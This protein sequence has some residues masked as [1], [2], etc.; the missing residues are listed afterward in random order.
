MVIREVTATGTGEQ[1]FILE[2]ESVAD[3]NRAVVG[4]EIA[5]ALLGRGILTGT[6]GPLTDLVN[7]GICEAYDGLAGVIRVD[8]QGIHRWTGEARVSF[9]AVTTGYSH[10]ISLTKA[11]LI[12]LDS[13]DALHILPEGGTHTISAV[14]LNP[15]NMAREA[16]VAERRRMILSHE[17]KVRGLV[18]LIGLSRQNRGNER[19]SLSAAKLIGSGTGPNI[20]LSAEYAAIL[21]G[22]VERAPWNFTERATQEIVD[23]AWK[24]L[25]GARDLIQYEAEAHQNVTDAIRTTV[26]PAA[27]TEIEARVEAAGLHL[28]SYIG[29]HRRIREWRRDAIQAVVGT[30][31]GGTHCQYC[32]PHEVVQQL[33]SKYF[34]WLGE[35]LE[36]EIQLTAHQVVVTL[37]VRCRED[38]ASSPYLYILES[39]AA[40]L[41][42]QILT[43][44]QKVAIAY[45]PVSGY[46]TKEAMD[47]FKSLC[48]GAV[49]SLAGLTTVGTRKHVEGAILDSQALEKH[50]VAVH[51]ASLLLPPEI[52]TLAELLSDV[53]VNEAR[54]VMGI[55]AKA[56]RHDMPI[57]RST[58][59]IPITWQTPAPPQIYVEYLVRRSY[60]ASLEMSEARIVNALDIFCHKTGHDGMAVFARNTSILS[61]NKAFD[62]VSPVRPVR[63]HQFQ[64]DYLNRL[65]TKIVS[66]V[67]TTRPEE[68]EQDVGFEPFSGVEDP[69]L[70]IDLGRLAEELGIPMS[71][72]LETDQM[73]NYVDTL[74]AVMMQQTGVS[75][76]LRMFEY[77]RA[78]S[79]TYR[80]A[81]MANPRNSQNRIRIACMVLR[82][83]RRMRV[84]A[85][86]REDLLVEDRATYETFVNTRHALIRDAHEAVHPPTQDESGASVT[87]SPM[88]VG[89]LSPSVSGMTWDGAADFEETCPELPPLRDPLSVSP[90]MPITTPIRPIRR[91]TMYDELATDIAMIRRIVSRAAV[92]DEMVVM[93]NI[94]TVQITYLKTI[95]GSGKTTLAFLAAALVA[96][97]KQHFRS[98]LPYNFEV[99]FVCDQPLVRLE[100]YQKVVDLRGAIKVTIITTDARGAVMFES[101]F[102]EHGTYTQNGK[103]KRCFTE[104]RFKC[105]TRDMIIMA[106]NM[107]IPYVLGRKDTGTR[108][109]ASEGLFYGNHRAFVI[110]DEFGAKLGDIDTIRAFAEAGGD[111][112]RVADVFR[113]VIPAMPI[114]ANIP[115]IIT[116]LGA[117][118]PPMFM[119]TN[120]VATHQGTR[121]IDK[122]CVDKSGK[123][124][125]GSQ[126]EL[127]DGT[128]IHFWNV[129]P[130]NL[131]GD[132]FIGL[133]E[134]LVKRTVGHRA[135]VSLRDQIAKMIARE[136]RTTG[137]LREMEEYLNYDL[138]TYT[139]DS[140]A[141]YAVGLLYFMYL[142]A[143]RYIGPAPDLQLLARDMVGVIDAIP[144]VETHTVPIPPDAPWP[145]THFARAS[146]MYRAPISVAA[147]NFLS[148]IGI[149]N[150]WPRK[151]P[152]G[153]I[154]AARS[155]GLIEAII[156]LQE[157][158]AAAVETDGLIDRI[159]RFF[160]THAPDRVR[161]AEE[162]ARKHAG[163]D[164]EIMEVLVRK[165][166]P[167]P[168]AETG[169]SAP[170]VK[171]EAARRA[172]TE[173][174]QEVAE[175]AAAVQEPDAA[176]LEQAK[177]R[178]DAVA[179]DTENHTW[180]TFGAAV[181]HLREAS[182]DRE[183]RN[184]RLLL[185]PEPGR[186]A[187][188]LI[189]ALTG[190]TE[191]Q[192]RSESVQ[193][194]QQQ[195][196]LIE[197]KKHKQQA[198]VRL[199]EQGLRRGINAIEGVTRDGRTV[200]Q[201]V[202]SQVDAITADRL[203]ASATSAVVG[204]V[205]PHTGNRYL[206]P[207]APKMDDDGDLY[208][209]SFGIVCLSGSYG[210]HRNAEIYSYVKRPSR[211]SRI[212]LIIMDA[213]GCY[214]LNPNNATIAIMS[215]RAGMFVSTQTLQQFACR[216]GRAGTS[217]DATV[218]IDTLT[219]LRLLEAS[220]HSGDAALFPNIALALDEMRSEARASAWAR[221]IDVAAADAYNAADS[222]VR[223]HLKDLAPCLPRELR[224][225][226]N[227]DTYR[228]ILTAGLPASEDRDKM[229]EETDQL[230]LLRADAPDGVYRAAF[231]S[232]LARRLTSRGQTN[233]DCELLPFIVGALLLHIHEPLG[234][235]D[236]PAPAK[237]RKL[238]AIWPR[239]PAPAR[240]DAMMLIEVLGAVALHYSQARDQ[241]GYELV[242]KFMAAR[243][244]DGTMAD[245]TIKSIAQNAIMSIKDASLDTT[246]KTSTRDGDEDE[247]ETSRR[248]SDDTRAPRPAPLEAAVIDRTVVGAR[249]A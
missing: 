89:A 47:E 215:P 146:E 116:V 203:L 97:A 106:S 41:V 66:E 80:S 223:K 134:P 176:S 131:I 164:A 18:G 73:V 12:G 37:I 179:R 94:D 233:A 205:N 188:R 45:D 7:C 135:V 14:P 29:D 143:H 153:A 122:P 110:I 196:E 175:A 192:V 246:A 49:A 36:K 210:E 59:F 68:K 58:V 239:S 142:Y 209:L 86:T 114:L 25:G 132:L 172:L 141:N 93:Q 158:P 187:I 16:L 63:P 52:P 57:T 140:V 156:S 226:L 138:G 157:Q 111:K 145:R 43:A 82:R 102:K 178:G 24:I 194:I 241:S 154:L 174:Q 5:A 83:A 159:E 152:Y 137:R 107:L 166:G 240:G 69:M 127:A 105:G 149:R 19:L 13:G 71:E 84:Y 54:T 249:L 191:K 30:A 75:V 227:S 155:T 61:G 95:A 225:L 197:N 15:G 230:V 42:E 92:S 198:A 165:Y 48:P 121:V 177:F 91:L 204:S 125:V 60:R 90:V 79:T 27:M 20:T 56:V 218:I 126:F 190:R 247:R 133:R 87:A 26:G 88:T 220:I 144:G 181:R 171:S 202:D 81:I 101:N 248:P 10:S 31:R 21:L 180:T 186:A 100:T 17:D 212:T 245:W 201:R 70:E 221:S 147:P 219:L 76:L 235:A 163:R 195:R 34:S 74:C 99:V 22:V 184:I 242:T 139:G 8:D 109:T 236:L 120:T 72:A 117:S 115:S 44:S 35:P 85:A 224:G 160:A 113:K 40:E 169:P 193:K 62:S 183:D 98:S 78:A 231:A 213:G 150:K 108:A 9:Q 11:A 33:P 4:A 185:D 23:Y 182:E 2:W 162:L 32:G 77:A 128:E 67:M 130:P 161:T 64:R 237:Q 124:Y 46:L 103:T 112:L 148:G 208:V 104:P 234:V 228:A 229:I 53:G 39:V 6:Y 206:D 129:C 167:E 238:A 244:P 65:L 214:G 222:N 170:A 216:V 189:A 3:T 200:S 207:S 55:L 50:V 243:M 118:L 151:V 136:S 211:T 232:E 173:L 217:D 1:R 119:L 123:I 199:V 51:G 96:I 38:G 168:P 28:S